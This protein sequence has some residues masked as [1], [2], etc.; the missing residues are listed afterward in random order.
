MNYTYGIICETFSLNEKNR[1]A[2]G[3]AVF[4]HTDHTESNAIIA[5]VNDLSSDKESVEKLIS[6]CNEGQLS[7]IHLYDVVD[8]YLAK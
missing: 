8:D 4:A 3:I 5:T 1:T 2:Y 7:L 6:A